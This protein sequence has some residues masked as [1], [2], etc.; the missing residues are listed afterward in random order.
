MT[1]EVETM[2]IEETQKLLDILGGDILELFSI[3]FEKIQVELDDL[4]MKE[5]MDLLMQIGEL[6][7][8]I[9][10]AVSSFGLK[11]GIECFAKSISK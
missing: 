1:K 4:D 2:G 3:D 11:Q 9:M 7:L 8:R 6:V 5:K 10:G